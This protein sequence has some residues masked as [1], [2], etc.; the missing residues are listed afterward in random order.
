[1]APVEDRIFVGARKHFRAKYSTAEVG[2]GAGLLVCLGLI[3]AWVMWKGEHAAPELTAAAPLVRREPPSDR[4]PIP[5]GWARC[6]A[7]SRLS[8][9]RSA[10]PAKEPPERDYTSV[11]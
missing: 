2:V 5:A 4:G 11:R 9:M 7:P 3:A 10:C 8:G 6:P 1:M